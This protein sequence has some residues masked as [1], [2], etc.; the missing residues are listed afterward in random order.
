MLRRW[1]Q[2]NP[3][4]GAALRSAAAVFKGPNVGEVVGHEAFRKVPAARTTCQ[5][6]RQR[7]GGGRGSVCCV[8]VSR[9]H[10]AVV[11]PSRLVSSRLPFTA[12]PE[13]SAFR[14]AA[15]GESG[16]GLGKPREQTTSN[17]KKQPFTAA[18]RGKEEI[19]IPSID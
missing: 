13:K 7:A 16:T 18:V 4:P 15:T 10:V 5:K 3:L 1:Q 6:K 19:Y 17:H 9:M 8:L 2:V 11:G 14:T 12:W